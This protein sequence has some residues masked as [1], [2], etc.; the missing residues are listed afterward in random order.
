MHE[1]ESCG[2]PSSGVCGS[3]RHDEAPHLR[4]RL[5]RRS[6]KSL[7]EQ[8]RAEGGPH[9]VVAV[10]DL[11]AARLVVSQRPVRLDRDARASSEADLLAPRPE[12]RL[13]AAEHRRVDCQ[14]LD[15]G[16][17]TERFGGVASR[18]VARKG[19]LSADKGATHPVELRDDAVHD[20][21]RNGLVDD[22]HS[23]RAQ[24]RVDLG[25]GAGL[26]IQPREL[27]HRRA[28]PLVLVE[29]VAGG[30]RGGCGERVGGL[31]VCVCVRARARYLSRE[32]PR[33]GR[34]TPAHTAG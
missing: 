19:V 17:L 13:D 25:R 33:E 34:R 24:Q 2:R 10:Q 26:A 16:G 28:H 29:D 4:G 8:R 1:T 14:L 11:A 15:C 3:Q 18:V 23:V 12:K 7:R 5:S 31:H 20:L 21:A 6:E 30:E 22:H 27:H 32:N 9:R